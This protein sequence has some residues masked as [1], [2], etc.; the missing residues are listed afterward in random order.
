[1]LE[2]GDRK[3]CSF[4]I[5]MTNAF[6]RSHYETRSEHTEIYFFCS[7]MRYLFVAFITEHFHP[8]RQ[9]YEDVDKKRYNQSTSG[10]AERRSL[11]RRWRCLLVR[12]R[13]SDWQH[14]V[15]GLHRGQ[16]R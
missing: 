6:I 11:R 7:F 12:P 8:R 14:F 5:A 13:C 16:Q 15:E 4:Y 9:S 1:M 2:N 3:N 10:S